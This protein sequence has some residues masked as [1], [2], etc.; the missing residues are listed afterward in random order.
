MGV[1]DEISLSVSTCE[2][3]VELDPGPSL[4]IVE[5]KD[6]S[7]NPRKAKGDAPGM[8]VLITAMVPCQGRRI[9][10]WKTFGKILAC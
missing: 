5:A 10:D 2:A 6:F 4:V 8:A 7:N 3:A 1:N 9:M